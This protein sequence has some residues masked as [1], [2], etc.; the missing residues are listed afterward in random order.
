MYFLHQ[1]RWKNIANMHVSES[2]RYLVFIFW[3]ENRKV[4]VKI[5]YGKSSIN[6]IFLLS[7]IHIGW[8]VKIEKSGWKCNFLQ[9]ISYKCAKFTQH[10]FSRTRKLRYK[11]GLVI[12][13]R[14]VCEKSLCSP[15]IRHVQVRMYMREINCRRLWNDDA[16]VADDL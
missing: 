9:K 7:K 2:E 16:C 3:S 5:Q 13:S 8:I 15:N 11:W 10:E 4:Y 12:Y 6:T 14:Y 1:F